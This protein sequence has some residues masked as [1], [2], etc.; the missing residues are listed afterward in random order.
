MTFLK[1]HLANQARRS[2]W[3]AP[4]Y[5]VVAHNAGCAADRRPSQGNEPGK[6]ALTTGSASGVSHLPICAQ[7]ILMQRAKCNP[8]ND[9]LEM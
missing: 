2:R 8:S 6:K 7:P 9:T 5:E 3:Q 1:A 4:G